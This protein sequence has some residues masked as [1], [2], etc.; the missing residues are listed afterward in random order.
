MNSETLTKNEVSKSSV[1]LSLSALYFLNISD[2]TSTAGAHGGAPLF[3]LNLNK[4]QDS[5]GL[6]LKV[7]RLNRQESRVFTQCSLSVER[8][9]RGKFD[10]FYTPREGMVIENDAQK[11]Q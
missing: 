10:F 11:G 3:S 6:S 4:R 2:Q 8:I 7:E 1:L 5:T 9:I